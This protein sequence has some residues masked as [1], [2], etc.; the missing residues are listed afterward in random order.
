MNVVAQAYAGEVQR[1]CGTCTWCCDVLEIPE[2][3]KP[4]GQACPHSCNA[5]AIYTQR[6]PS[7]RN[8]RCTWVMGFGRRRDRPDK[9][10]ALVE[11]RDGV[12]GLGLYA[13]IPAGDQRAMDV[14]ERLSADTGL[15]VYL[16]D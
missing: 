5:C 8:F 10:R 6:P 16:V 2:L 1:P 12:M 3:A 13:T 4:F 9:S 14:L 15:D 7:C 11:Y